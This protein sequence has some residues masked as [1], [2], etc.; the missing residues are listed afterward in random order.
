LSLEFSRGDQ[1][2][3]RAPQVQLMLMFS[4]PLQESTSMVEVFSVELFAE[5]L[6][7][8]QK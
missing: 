1:E 6:L 3:V 7:Q 4:I 2:F 8:A 5:A